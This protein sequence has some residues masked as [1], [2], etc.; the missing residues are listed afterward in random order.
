MYLSDLNHLSNANCLKCVF[1]TVVVITN[2]NH[3][4]SIIVIII[5][6][7]NCLTLLV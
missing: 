5:T 6:I 2:D 1:V 3:G 4:N 7:N